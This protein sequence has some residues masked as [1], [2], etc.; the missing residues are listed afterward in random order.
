[1]FDDC[2]LDE[3]GDAKG[4]TVDTLASEDA[5][6]KEVWSGVVVGKALEV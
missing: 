1:M 4:K 5:V 2:E 3:L 6:R